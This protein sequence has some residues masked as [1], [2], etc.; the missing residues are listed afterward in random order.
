MKG[1]SH[2]SHK[3]SFVV[4]TLVEHL[5]AKGKYFCQYVCHKVKFMH[6][7]VP[8]LCRFHVNHL[9]DNEM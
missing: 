4:L 9:D 3:F 8:V 6:I 7:N 5:S 1:L 2:C